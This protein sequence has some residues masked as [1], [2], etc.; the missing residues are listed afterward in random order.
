MASGSDAVDTGYTRSSETVK[1][2]S[3]RKRAGPS[4]KARAI[5]ILS[6]R[7][8]SRLELQRKLAPHAS[9]PDELEP[10]LDELERQKWL[11]TERFAHSLVHRRAASRGTQR[12]VQELRQH[13]VADEDV[14][15]LS[16]QLQDTEADRAREVWDRKF[17][18]LATTQKEYARQYRFLASR[19]FSTDSVRRLLGSMPPPE[20]E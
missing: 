17:G 5:D 15:Q 19:G 18:Q 7:E 2:A 4:L 12:I 8:H 9:D 16:E 11:S 13:G 3:T 6:R 14:A 1:P 10:L 20:R